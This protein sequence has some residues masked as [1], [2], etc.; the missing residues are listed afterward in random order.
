[1]RALSP[2]SG[3]TVNRG[4]RPEWRDDQRVAVGSGGDSIEVEIE[5]QLGS[6][7]QN[8][9]FGRPRLSTPP[10]PTGMK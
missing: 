1:M 2:V 4:P 5:S 7:S 9:E 6:W 10:G 3:S 8:H